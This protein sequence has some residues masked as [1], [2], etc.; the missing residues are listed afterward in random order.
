M[1][2]RFQQG[3]GTLV[4]YRFVTTQA[5][6]RWIVFEWSVKQNFVFILF[7]RVTVFNCLK[8]SFSRL[9]KKLFIPKNRKTVDSEGF[10]SLEPSLNL[11]RIQAGDNQN[12]KFEFETAQIIWDFAQRERP[13]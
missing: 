2:N 4:F 10:K 7:F 11:Y 13:S 8:N 12:F 9:I 1:S 6:W 5:F 3:E